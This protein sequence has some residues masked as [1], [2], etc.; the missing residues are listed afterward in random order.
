MSMYSHPFHISRRTPAQRRPT[1]L[2]G[3]SLGLL[4][5]PGRAIRTAEREGYLGIDLDMRN[6]W[7]AP[8]VATMRALHA[9]H[10][11]RVRCVWLPASIRGPLA[12]YRV[13]RL[14]AFLRLAEKELGLRQVVVGGAASAPAQGI[15]MLQMLQQSG[16]LARIAIGVR[17]DHTVHSLAG[18]T[19]ARRIAEEWD[20]D[21][22]LDLSGPVPPGWE[23]EAAV[24]RMLSRLTIVRL[25]GWLPGAGADVNESPTR[26]A[27]RSIAM[28]ADQGF[29]GLL[30]IVPTRNRYPLED[31]QHDLQRRYW[32]GPQNT[33]LP[34]NTHFDL[35]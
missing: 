4:G 24:M 3:A 22:A 28:L 10:V 23:A 30:S 5:S 16:I 33:D 31:Y 12:A 20:L 17:A 11:V 35:P 13:D 27:A 19:Q 29:S 18:T 6:R 25:C 8:D 9:H 14:T 34:A 26:I 15:P 1:I 2:F 21:L 7:L 32:L